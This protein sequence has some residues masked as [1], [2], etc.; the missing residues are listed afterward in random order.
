MG[1][2][3]F[4]EVKRFILMKKNYGL[5]TLFDWIGEWIFVAG[6]IVTALTF[7]EE[8]AVGQLFIW[9]V[10]WVLIFE[11]IQEMELE[12]R[13]NQM[14]N[15]LSLKNN[16]FGTYLY[17]GLIYLVFGSLLF[18]GILFLVRPASLPELGSFLVSGNGLKMVLLN[19]PLL[20]LMYLLL[21]TWAQYFERISTAVS[22]IN[23]LSL[24]LSGLVFQTLPF[25]YFTYAA[26]L[27][28]VINWEPLEVIVYLLLLL[29]LSGLLVKSYR[30]CQRKIYLA[31]GI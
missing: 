28:G 29:L 24:M 19:A 17:R 18:V 4:A 2:K 7:Q 6:L 12:I 25:K 21:L 9:Y 16:L 23:T 1:R 11:G 14:K 15:L 30:S 20:L 27:E 31:G 26:I 13:R 10:G 5:D 22:F 3:L 8:V